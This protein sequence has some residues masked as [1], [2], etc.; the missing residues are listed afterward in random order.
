MT[1]AL[2][3]LPSR[4]FFDTNVVNF[5]FDNEDAIFENQRIRDELSESDRLNV[6]SLQALFVTG[7]RVSWE[8]AISPITYHEVMATRQAGRRADL[9]NWFNELWIYWREIVAEDEGISDYLAEQKAQDVHLARRLHCFPDQAD[10]QLIAH[11]IAYKCDVF[12]TRDVRTILR[13]RDRAGDI[14][15]RL[16]SPAELGERLRPWVHLIC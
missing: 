1:L 13:R 7:Q 4:I 16:I 2:R 6:I 3:S 5:V 8:I 11:A 15:I 10:R 14:P 12:C 9:L